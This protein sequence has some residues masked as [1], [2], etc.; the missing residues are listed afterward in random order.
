MRKP[1]KISSYICTQSKVNDS[2][3]TTQADTG[4]IFTN[5]AYATSLKQRTYNTWYSLLISMLH[6]NSREEKHTP[7]RKTQPA[8][9]CSTCL[10]PHGAKTHYP[11]RLSSERAAAETLFRPLPASHGV[12]S[13]RDTPRHAEHEAQHQ[14]C[15]YHCCCR[16]CVKISRH[17]AVTQMCRVFCALLE[18]Q[19]V[20]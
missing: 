20:I 4:V 12:V 9:V 11:Q 16:C 14:F 7:Q 10:L 15:Y 3:G 1:G 8:V 2:S 18:Q 17:P 6:V 19:H 13:W 5:Q